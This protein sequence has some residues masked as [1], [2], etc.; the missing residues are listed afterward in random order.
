MNR[1]EFLATLGASAAAACSPLTAGADP[2]ALRARPGT[3]AL[4]IGPGL[5]RL[6]LHPSRDA[7]L[8]VPSGYRAGV[9]HP[10]LVLL[11]GAGQS[12]G[13]WTGAEPLERML[14][15]RGILMLAPDSRGVTWEHGDPR[16]A[17]FIDAALAWTFARAFVAPA[18]IALGGFSDGAS[19]ALSLGL[20]NGPLFPSLLAFSP[21]YISTTARQGKPRV[22]VS[23]GMSDTILPYANA[24]RIV[25][26]LRAESYDVEFE[27]FGGGHT[28]GPVVA[29]KA[30]DWFS[31]VPADAAPRARDR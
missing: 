22:F 28:I 25:A 30:L 13:E 21:C 19:F 11:H 7:S 16:D 20:Y 15:E 26:S 10:L 9:A 5:H 18:R 17:A 1:R 6:G 8:F 24:R 23:H 29:T 4:S 31:R 3:P 12:S 2:F 14:D 27:S